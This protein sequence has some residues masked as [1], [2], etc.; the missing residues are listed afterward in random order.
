MVEFASDSKWRE[1]GLKALSAFVV[2]T[3]Y[4]I[5]FAGLVAIMTGKGL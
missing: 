1:R 4:L 5:V 2:V 3:S